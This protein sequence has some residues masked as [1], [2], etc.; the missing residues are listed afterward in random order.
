MLA[1]NIHNLYFHIS[2]NLYREYSLHFCTININ[3]LSH[4][5]CTCPKISER[6]GVSSV[7]YYTKTSDKKGTRGESLRFF[8]ISC[9]M[10]KLSPFAVCEHTRQLVH[11]DK[12]EIRIRR[13]C[14]GEIVLTAFHTPF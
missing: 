7:A 14:E 9:F 6:G 13:H 3:I 10:F 8:D 4:K 2:C 1:I 12:K 5:Y 11:R